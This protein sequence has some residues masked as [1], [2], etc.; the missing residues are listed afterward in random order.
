MNETAI[1]GAACRLPGAPDEARFRQMLTDGTCA[2]RPFPTGR[3]S[4]ERFLH[5]RATEPGFSYSFAGGYLDAPFDFDPTVFGMSPREAA[6]VDPQQRLLMEV[7]WEA[8]EDAR[9]APSSLAGHEVGV[10]VGASSLDHGNLLASDPAAIESHFMTG[11]TLSVVSNRL[12]YAFDWHGPSFTVDTACSSSLVAFSQALTDLKTGRIDTAVVA[13]VNMLLTPA[14]YIGFSRASMLSPTGLC[15]P[16][17]AAGDGYVRSEGAVAFV[18]RRRDLALPGSIRALAIAGAVNSDGR[19]SGIA[20]PGVEGQ[21]A[22]IERLYGETGITPDQVAFVEAH[23]TGTRIGDPVEATAIG[24]VLGRGRSAPLPIGSVKSNIGH[25]EPASGVAGILKAVNALETRELPRSLHL[26]ELN[27]LIDFA[28]LNLLPAREAVPLNKDAATLFAGISSFGFGGT[29]AHI[30]LASAPAD[31][32]PA[33]TAASAP[34]HITVSAATAEALRTLAGTTADALNSGVTPARL[35]AALAGGRELMRHRAVAVLDEPDALQAGFRELADTGASKAIA[36]GAAGRADGKVCFVYSGN[37]AQVVGMGRTAYLRNP[38]FRARFD[39]IDTAFKALEGRGVKEDMFDPALADRI[40]QASVIQPLMFAVQAALTAGLVAEGLKPDFLIGHSIGEVAAA[41]ASGA[42]DLAQAVRIIHARATSQEAAH[43]RGLMAVFAASR[44][45]MEEFLAGFGRDDIEIAADNGP[46]SLTLS[47]STEAIKLATREARRQR[48]ASRTLEMAYP[49]HSHLLEDT[50]PAFLTALGDIRPRPATTTLVSTVT[51][52]PA[53]EPLDTAYWWRNVRAP[54]LFRSALEAASEAGATL[55]IELGPRPIL[56][57]PITDTLK[58]RGSSAAVLAS[59]TEADDRDPRRDP[60]LWV[61]ANARA[62]GAEA[63]ARPATSVDRSLI[64][65]TYPWQRSTFHFQGTSAALDLFGGDARHPLIGGRLAEGVPEWR[66]FLD[67]EIVPYLAD[68]VVDGEIVVPAAAIVE[69]V[70]AVGRA[71][72]PEGPLG[73]EDCDIFQP[74]VLSRQS[75]REISVRHAAATNDVELFSRPRFGTDEW[76]LHARGRL[77]EVAHAPRPTAKPKGKLIR[78]TAAEI[79]ARTQACGLHYGPAFQLAQSIRRDA[80]TIEVALTPAEAGTGAFTRPQLLHPAS[81]DAALHGLF[82]L[83]DM[84]PGV[85]RTYLP[86]RLGRMSLFRDH[87]VVTAATIGVERHTAHSLKVSI[88]LKDAEGTVVAEVEEALLKSVVFSRTDPD[89]GFLYL[90]RART[91]AATDAT[92]LAAP[93]LAHLSALPEAEPTDGWL[94]LR[95]AMRAAAHRTLIALADEAG[96]LDL[97][98]LAATGRIAPEARAFAALLGEELVMA[99]LATRDGEALVIAADSGLPEPDRILRTFAADYPEA[100]ADL[101]LVARTIAEMDETLRT[102]AAIAHRAEILEQFAGEGVL[103]APARIALLAAI[104][105]A[106]HKQGDAPPRVLVAE[107]DGRA[108]IAA[109]LPEVRAG[110]IRLTVAGR[111]T[112]RLERLERRLPANLAVS[113]LKL[114]DQTPTATHDLAL[115]STWR[116][117]GEEGAALVSGLARSL[118]PTGALVAAQPAPDAVVDFILG[119]DPDWFARSADPAFP[120]GLMPSADETRAALAAAGCRDIRTLE[121]AEGGACLVARAPATLPPATAARP[122]RLVADAASPLAGPLTAHLAAAGLLA[123]EDAADADVI[124]LADGTTGAD[125]PRVEAQVLRLA[126][127]LNSRPTDAPKSRLWLVVRGA[128]T[129]QLDPVADALWGFGRVALNEV[130]D[131]GLHLVDIAPGLPEAEAVARLAALLV[132][133][134]VERETVLDARGA[135][136]TRVLKGVPAMPGAADPEAALT[137]EFPRRGALD[138]FAWAKKVRTAPGKGDVEIEVLAA[139]LNFRDVMLAMGLLDD[140]VLDDGMA[141][142]VFG[143][144]CAGRVTRVGEKVTDLAVG[145]VV[146]GFAKNAFSTHVTAPRRV[147]MPLPAGTTPDSAASIPVA[148]LTAWYGLVELA[149]LKRGESVLIHGAAGGVGLAAIQIAKARGAKVIATVSTADKRALVSLMGADAIYDSRSLAFADTIRHSHGGVDVVLNSLSGEAMRASFK[150]LKPFGRFVELGKRDYVANTE[151]GLRPFRRNLTYFGVDLDQLLAHDPRLVA[152]GLK[153]LAAGFDKGVY[154]ALPCRTFGADGIGEA[155]RLMQSAAHVGKIVVR[156]PAAGDIRLPRV[157]ADG[158][159]PEGVQLVVGGA[160]GFGLETA[161]WL[162]A[163]GARTIVVASRRGAVDAADQPRID[164]LK[165]AGITFAVEQVDVS[166]EASV[167]ALVAR[168][169]DTHGPIGGVY[170]TA[171]VLHD[172]LIRTLETDA[173]ARVLAPKVDGARHLDRATR[174]QPVKHFVLFSSVSALI[175]NPGQGAYVAANAY[176]EGIA[177]RRATEGLPA[178]AIGWGAISDA[179]VLARDTS[180]AEQLER[181]TGMTGM[182]AA[183][184]LSRLER[185]LATDLAEP[186]VYCARWQRTGL[187]RDLPILATPAFAA[188]FAEDGGAKDAAELDLAALLEGKSDTEALA[189]LGELVAGR[190]AR[191][192]R[193]SAQEID[194]D[195]P[196]AEM[197]MD[198]LMALELSMSIEHEFGVALPLVAITSVP[199]VRE[200]SRR[201]LQSLRTPDTG[202]TVDAGDHRLIA[203]HGGDVADFDTVGDAL[204]NRRDQVTRVM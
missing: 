10:Y 121:I 155:F 194:L 52:A 39:E 37:G 117:T 129:T 138:H 4:V 144:E 111:D 145:D 158:F 59:F 93:I 175:G 107:P 167:T 55:F 19:T 200:L 2:I 24:S 159:V 5:P 119:S 47:G 79:Y 109:L 48:I 172:G 204:A 99:D 112:A 125:Q 83:I 171:M 90:G 186:V 50:R 153:D 86:I 25:L 89:D 33:E 132:G 58:E 91:G 70:L 77:V 40:G 118:V 143:F 16:F 20:L 202:P 43:G 174:D 131:A 203:M 123:P 181:V 1:V 187:M 124:V 54:V 164:A 195:R 65:P 80:R 22:L 115:I 108:V 62:H 137:L 157:A 82:Q 151:L 177:R 35:A 11:N 197:G 113:F 162:A 196:F 28:D 97:D 76:T 18:L 179:G 17:S 68:H 15:R 193:L 3:W 114:D 191:I 6:Q 53:T 126:T 133:P 81:L 134:G 72:K 67:A 71:L 103:F 41:E 128:Q 84:E 36:T 46:N 198:S 178:L 135:Q 27:P 147:F 176:L 110:R 87:P 96:R 120:V 26:D 173:L 14:S 30:I 184:A 141:G 199:N 139:G 190:I 57:S 45:R 189:I 149:K 150:C 180:T 160:G 95:A 127:L 166:A 60:V 185:L 192:L 88:A 51:G 100:A 98:L 183:D 61:V 136:V 169:A 140:D 49:F 78:T 56:T 63:P 170:H 146:V 168:V 152:K 104:A 34:R 7:V 188:V 101:L 44:T 142:A 116:L 102:G 165:A 66:T 163:K 8:L 94:M 92:D 74:L 156:P 23:G 161:L 106:Q 154:T 75:M 13:G 31:Q 64:L 9:I 85:R 105:A 29:N 38:A 12:S 148:F 73:L 201:L 32:Q 122:V 130:A 21:R 69:M 42:I 182:T